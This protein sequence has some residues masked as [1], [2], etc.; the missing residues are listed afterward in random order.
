MGRDMSNNNGSSNTTGR[1][2]GV[3]AITG[4]ILLLGSMIWMIIH[5]GFMFHPVGYTIAWI[6]WT[7]GMAAMIHGGIRWLETPDDM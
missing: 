6:L 5:D 2:H 1:L 4:M 7:V 3:I